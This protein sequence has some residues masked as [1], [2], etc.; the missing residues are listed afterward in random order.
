MRQVTVNMKIETKGN[1]AG[2]K[3]QSSRE[4]AEGLTLLEF[5]GL[6]LLEF[7]DLLDSRKNRFF[8]NPKR[9][10]SKKVLE[11]DGKHLD[12]VDL[13]FQLEGYFYVGQTIEG[14]DAYQYNDCNDFMYIDTKRCLLFNTNKNIVGYYVIKKLQ[15]K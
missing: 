3:R 12:E 9:I 11:A 14:L 4:A 8:K 7:Y 1:W 6:T 10:P 2:L 15:S 13:T 5:Y